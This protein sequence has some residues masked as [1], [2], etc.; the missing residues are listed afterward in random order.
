MLQQ[1]AAGRSDTPDMSNLQNYNRH[2]RGAV[3]IVLHRGHPDPRDETT[4]KLF[5]AVRLRIVSTAIIRHKANVSKH[6]PGP[7]QCSE[8]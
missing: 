6:I 7:R 4:L 5:R 3:D 8:N 1:N 2:I